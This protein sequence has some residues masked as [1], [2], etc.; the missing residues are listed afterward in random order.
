MMPTAPARLR[1]SRRLADFL[2]AILVSFISRSMPSKKQKGVQIA[3]L[4]QMNALVPAAT[5]IGRSFLSS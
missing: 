4:P 5:A 2:R 3:G 1:K